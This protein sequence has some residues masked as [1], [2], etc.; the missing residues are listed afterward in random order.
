VA[1]KPP[2]RTVLPVQLAFLAATALIL[3]VATSPLASTFAPERTLPLVL[4]V[5]AGDVAIF[6][7]FGHYLV[8]RPRF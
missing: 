7:A 2:L 8:T 1:V 6:I 4:A 3:G 5:V